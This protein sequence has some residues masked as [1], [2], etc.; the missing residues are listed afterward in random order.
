M[1]HRPSLGVCFLVA[2]ELFCSQPSNGPQ[3]RART[4]L[5]TLPQYAV[6]TFSKR[7]F[8]HCVCVILSSPWSVCPSVFSPNASSSCIQLRWEQSQQSD[9]SSVDTGTDHMGLH[10]LPPALSQSCHHLRQLLALNL[11]KSFWTGAFTGKCPT[12]VTALFVNTSSLLKV[13]FLPCLLG[14]TSVSF[15]NTHFQPER[16]LSS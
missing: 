10:W 11:T 7:Y 9:V 5:P 12:P 1:H 8:C 6:H 16:R 2:G 3:H 13:P 14:V 15:I 4:V